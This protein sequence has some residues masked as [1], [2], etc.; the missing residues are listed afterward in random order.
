ML[1]LHQLSLN[2]IIVILSFEPSSIAFFAKYFAVVE[3]S[4]Y[5]LRI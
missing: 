5:Y 4:P 3:V 1:A 2:T